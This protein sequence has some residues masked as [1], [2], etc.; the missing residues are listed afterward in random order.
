MRNI[1]ADSITSKDVFDAAVAG[2]EMAQNIFDFTGT[3]LG[4][5]FADFIKFSSPEAIIL[6]GGLAHA[7]DLLLNPIVK[8]MNENLMPVFRNKVK[9]L[10]SKMK[11]ADAAI[12]G[13]SAL[14]W[15][16]K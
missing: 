10:F 12:L 7:G 5:A 4:E 15:D 11:D 6:F 2:D 1:P 3:V 8:S 9:V 16:F 13:A 14:A